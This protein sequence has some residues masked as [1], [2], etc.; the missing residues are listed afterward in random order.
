MVS[1]IPENGFIRT[2]FGPFLP[3]FGIRTAR[4][5]CQ[6]TAA[7]LNCPLDVARYFVSI[8]FTL[9]VTKDRLPWPAK[10]K[11]SMEVVTH[12]REVT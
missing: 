1:R 2:V 11:G 3:V 12:R 5:L 6:D 8:G 10:R 7:P 4:A 9:G